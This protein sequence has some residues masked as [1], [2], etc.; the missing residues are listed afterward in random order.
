MKK[1]LARYAGVIGIV[2]LLLAFAT[3]QS[4][5][6]SPDPDQELRARFSKALGIDVDRIVQH[7]YLVK[8]GGV[9]ELA[10]KDPADTAAIDAIRKFLVEQRKLYEKGKNETDADVH[11][12]VP[13]G[14]PL[15]KKFRD[16]I[17]FFATDTTN[18]AVL[19]MFSMNPTARSAIQDYM[20][21]QI[22]EHKTGDSP[23]INQ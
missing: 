20:K 3:A 4:A 11:G 21:F 15:I 12:K 2:C 16:E 17:T 23:T 14:L 9:V 13:D 8:N 18:G 1:P 19:R 6:T 7:Y 10:A 22:A 5:A